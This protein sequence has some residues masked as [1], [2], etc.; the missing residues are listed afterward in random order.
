M[1]SEVHKYIETALEKKEKLF[2]A[3]VLNFPKDKKNEVIKDLK[4]K[5]ENEF[6]KINDESNDDQLKAVIGICYMFGALILMGLYSNL[7]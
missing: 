4:I 6:W 1:S 3:E 7:M 5:S 2:K